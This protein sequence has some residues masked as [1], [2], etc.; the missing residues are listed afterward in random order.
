MI[1]S[2]RL[3]RYEAAALGLLSVGG[4]RPDFALGFFDLIVY[5]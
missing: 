1:E 2:G 4:N 3:S 5:P